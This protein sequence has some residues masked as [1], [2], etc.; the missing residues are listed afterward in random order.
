MLTSVM[1]Q[2]RTDAIW[3]LVFII[4]F[5][6]GLKFGISLKFIDWQKKTFEKYVTTKSSS[7]DIEISNSICLGK[8]RTNWSNKKWRAKKH[9]SIFLFKESKWRSIRKT[10]ECF[11]FFNR[12]APLCDVDG[13]WVVQLLT[14][15]WNECTHFVPRA[16]ESVYNIGLQ[17]I[18]FYLRT[19]IMEWSNKVAKK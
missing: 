10:S 11:F 15:C 2:K 1:S 9:I 14:E 12:Y 6:L 17:R 7:A 5:G 13:E 18:F 19:Q 4:V 8:K 16:P 3:W